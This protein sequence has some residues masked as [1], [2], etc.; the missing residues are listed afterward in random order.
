MT[1]HRLQVS[2]ALGLALFAS[3]LAKTTHRPE[4]LHVDG[5]VQSANGFEEDAIR[6]AHGIA[7]GIL[8]AI[9][10]S[11]IVAVIGI[12]ACCICLCRACAGRN[13]VHHTV[14]YA[15]NPGGA[16]PHQQFPP[17]HPQWQPGAPGS[18]QPPPYS[19]DPQPVPMKG[20]L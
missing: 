2:L 6:E 13:E 16:Q 9:I 19:S 12:I 3:A 18:S 1:P 10:I 5:D 8:A 20:S 11:V 4:T 15:G 14:V 7:K 17:Q